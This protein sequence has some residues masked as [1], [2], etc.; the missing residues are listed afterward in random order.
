[1]KQIMGYS[2]KISV[3][4]GE[5]I[6]FMVSCEK[7]G[8]Y[9]ARIV[10][11]IHGDT[12]PEGPG[13]K[14]REVKSSIDG[15]YQARRQ[16]IHA[17]SYAVVPNQ[18][19]LDRLS[20]FSMQALVWPTTPEK[21][22]QTLMSRW[23]GK[24][25][26]GFTLGINGGNGLTL[27]LGDGKGGTEQVECGKPL[28]A[29]EWYF[30][31]ASYD[32][33]T[34]DVRLYQAPLVPYAKIDTASTVTKAVKINLQHARGAPFIFAAHLTDS[35]NGRLLVGGHYNGKI[36]R[37]RLANRALN[38]L[39]MEQLRGEEIPVSLQP[40]LVAAWDF[41]R[42]ITNEK[43]I[44]VSANRCHGETVQLPARAMTGSNWT[45]EEMCWRHK[46][47]QYGAIHFHDDDLYDSG[48]DVDFTL[49][50]PA[51]L[52]SGLYAAHVSIDEDEDFIPFVVRPEKGTSA[53]KVVFV[54]PTASYLAYANEHMAT[55]AP[56]AEH[57]TGQI[58]VFQ[59]TDV[60]LNEH[61]EYAGSCYDTHSDGSGVCYSSRLRPILTMRPK[62]Q[63]WLGGKGSS[64]W[65]MNADT[66]ITDW[67][68]AMGFDYDCATDEDLHNE[69]YDAIEPYRVFITSTHHEYWSKQMW[70]ALDAFKK[71]GGRLI[72]TGANAWYWRIAYH[73]SKPGVIEVR[74]AEGGIR[75][76]A[77]EPGEYYHSFTGEY[78]G[79]WRRQGQP[80]QKMAGTGFSAQGFDLSS[81]YRRNKDSFDERAAFIFAG[82]GKDELIG[83]FG[84][85]GG[86]AAGLELDRADRSLGT[87]PNALVL[88]SSE[89]HTPVYM[90]VLEEI[91]IN[92]PGLC[93]GESDLVR[94]D[95]VFFETPS[96]GAVFATSSIAWAGSLSHNNYQNNVSQITSN[97][98]KR[99]L[100]E[101]PF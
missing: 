12:N 49:T 23:G 93:N 54:V 77:A 31:A 41:A 80:P 21:G 2:D 33:G 97:V 10:Q 30:V 62:Y 18:P 34:G 69:G 14:E 52:K 68:E 99:F 55:D 45:G 91:F 11:I 87:P 50:V 70:E 28:H 46:P 75:A 86:G 5:S 27:T 61:R 100:D 25:K 29:R 60:F 96:G 22:H 72:Y 47:E 19:A 7:R 38:R 63:S 67:L 64:L 40:G 84:L 95:L 35:S 82:V 13:Y 57:L 71:A 94:A 4:P 65:Q 98:L 74:R 43:I 17:G 1:M 20:S 51:G 79:L 42:E 32:A 24:S 39:E 48:W 59:P 66:H 36:E 3:R 78:G 92:A 53:S 9:K 81:Y 83:N 76:W 26:T 101:K 8:S 58:A 85:I 37:P 16:Q 6:K 15:T 44:D 73:K 90:V 89:N 56:L 88:A